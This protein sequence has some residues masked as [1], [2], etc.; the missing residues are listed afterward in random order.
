[1]RNIIFGLIIAFSVAGTVYGAN[2]IRVNEKFAEVGGD[3]QTTQVYK[4]NDTENGTVCYFGYSKN[5]GKNSP[6]AMD[7]V[8][9]R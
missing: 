3:V 9:V 8:K 7:C 2:F 1:M 6:V 4:L 5:G